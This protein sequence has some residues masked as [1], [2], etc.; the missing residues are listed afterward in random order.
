M[1]KID[2]ILNDR[3]MNLFGEMHIS[4][5]KMKLQSDYI[6]PPF[7]VLDTRLGYW[8]DRVQ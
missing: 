1:S 7:S 3:Q 2:D 8:K 6:I 4:E 5:E